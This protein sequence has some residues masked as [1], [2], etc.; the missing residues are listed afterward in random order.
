MQFLNADTLTNWW[1]ALGPK[2]FLPSALQEELKSLKLQ[3]TLSKRRPI[4]SSFAE[5]DHSDAAPEHLDHVQ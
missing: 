4:A 3:R 1:M 2:L 5:S